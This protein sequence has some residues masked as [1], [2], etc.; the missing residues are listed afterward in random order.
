MK[1][2]KWIITKKF[3]FKIKCAIIAPN[4][5]E[6]FFIFPHPISFKKNSQRKNNKNNDTYKRTVR[7][8]T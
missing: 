1:D 3:P 4:K 7:F 2:R 8:R 5:K 6:V